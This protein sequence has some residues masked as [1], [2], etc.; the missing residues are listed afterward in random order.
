VIPDVGIEL[1]G[2]RLALL[3]ELVPH[4]AGFGFLAPSTA[5]YLA[6]RVVPPEEAKGGPDL[7]LAIAKQIVEMHGGRIWVESTL[8]KG[9]TL[10]MELLTRAEFRNLVVAD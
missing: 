5:G 9:S 7:G 10:Q 6:E 2:K 3:K 4:T 1:N 8:D